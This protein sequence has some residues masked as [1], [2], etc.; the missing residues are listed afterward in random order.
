MN[1]SENNDPFS[2]FQSWMAEARE[3]E[4]DDATAVALATATPEGRPS[5]R[6]VLLKDVIPRDDET[7]GFV[8]YTNL[9]SRKGGELRANPHAALCFHWKSLHR[10][11]RVEGPVVPVSDAEA[12]AYFASRA[13]ESRIG[14]W[15][16]RQSRPLES[17]WALEK[18]VASAAARFALGTIP[19]P[20]HWSG[21]RL[22]PERIEFWQEKPFRLHDRRV[23]LRENGDWRVEALYP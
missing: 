5:V 17:R 20:R 1:R 12:D 15:A 14:A 19:R 13:R 21:F 9:E 3:K 16:S 7:G 11:V 6:M 18:A 4:I 8:F 22:V 10:Q 23:F 2:L